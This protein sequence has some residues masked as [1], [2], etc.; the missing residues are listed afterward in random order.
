MKALLSLTLL[1]LSV[2][3]FATGSLYCSTPF[4]EYEFD[5]TTGRVPGN[6]LING[7][8]V[9]TEEQTVVYP[10]SQIVGYWAMGESMNFAITDENAEKLLYM[11]ETKLV[12]SD[13]GPSSVGV[14]TLHTGE[15][16][17]IKCEF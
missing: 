5:G 14:L 13:N 7:I 4:K 17:L 1:F 16:F 2:S 10:N 3:S 9:N 12:Y 8:L 15:N 6:P 11:V